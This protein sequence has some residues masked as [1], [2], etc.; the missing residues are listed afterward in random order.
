MTAGR[1]TFDLSVDREDEDE[2]ELVQFADSVTR[3]TVERSDSEAFLHFGDEVSDGFSTHEYGAHNLQGR[4]GDIYLENADDADGKLV[5]T[6]S[7][8]V[9]PELGGVSGKSAT[10]NDPNNSGGTTFQQSNLDGDGQQVTFLLSAEALVSFEIRDSGGSAVW[11]PL[12]LAGGQ[13]F[14]LPTPRRV[15]QGG[16]LF[17]DGTG[18]ANTDATVGYRYQE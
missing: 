8:D 16:S 5:L 2:Y 1:K 15:P 11:G 18:T 3:I 10:V 9:D 14:E 6:Y 12:T 7:R 17:M 13:S 4:T